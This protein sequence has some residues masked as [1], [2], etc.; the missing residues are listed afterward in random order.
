[1]SLQGTVIRGDVNS[2]AEL[3]DQSFSAGGA[4]VGFGL[5]PLRR[6]VA[7]LPM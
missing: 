4:R 6:G 2:Q 3:S 5:Q 1:M 7:V